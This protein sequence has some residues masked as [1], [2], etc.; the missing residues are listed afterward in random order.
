[1]AEHEEERRGKGGREKENVK[2][3]VKGK[4]KKRRGEANLCC[5]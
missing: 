2:R 1:M 3:G 4:E 5:I